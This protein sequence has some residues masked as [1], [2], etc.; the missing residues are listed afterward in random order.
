MATT[1]EIYPHFTKDLLHPKYWLLWI[2]IGIWYLLS[3]L[4]YPVIYQLGKG[5]GLLISKIMRKRYYTAR[6]NLQLCFPDMPESERDKMLR[7]NFISTGVAIFE[8]AMAWFWSDKR[9]KKRVKVIGDENIAEVQ[10]KGQGVL[11]LGVHFLTMELGGRILGM[12]HPGVGIYR[13][14]DNKVLDYMQLKGRLKSNKYMIG[15]YNTK[16]MI[17]A[18]KQGELV[19]YAPDHDYGRKNSVFAPFF[20]VDKAATTVGSNILVKLGDPAIIPYTPKREKNGQYVVY[21]SPK[22]EDYPS[23]SDD[24]VAATFMNNAIEN[25]ILKVP[26]QYMWL[27]RRFKTRPKGEEALYSEYVQKRKRKQR[28]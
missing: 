13:P 15:R 21:V 25:E 5:L 20:A 9:L 24:M 19:W 4:P 27:H 8:T 22:L 18:L 17:R 14:N 16:G 11:L 10:Q 2:G 26:E 12:L 28:K 7:D 6:E 23:G 1:Q 3:L